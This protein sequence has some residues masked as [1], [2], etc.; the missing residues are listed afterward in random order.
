MYIYVC[1]CVRIYVHI[2]IYSMYIYI[3]IYRHVSIYIDFVCW[4]NEFGECVNTLIRNFIKPYCLSYESSIVFFY[5]S[6]LT[7]NLPPKNIK[8]PASTSIKNYGF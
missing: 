7:Y 6:L 2:Y 8:N 4:I 1:V 3:Y 5:F